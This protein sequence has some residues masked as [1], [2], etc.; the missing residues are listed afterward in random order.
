MKA[1]STNSTAVNLYEH[2]ERFE[3]PL[4][5]AS[6]R[7]YYINDNK[8]RLCVGCCDDHLISQSIKCMDDQGYKEIHYSEV[9]LYNN[10]C[11]KLQIAGCYSMTGDTVSLK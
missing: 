3:G 2:L 7:I 11:L 8:T 6:L 5:R 1:K 9:V 4:Y 10:T